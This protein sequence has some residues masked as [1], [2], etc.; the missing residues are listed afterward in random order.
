[1]QALTYLR[2]TPESNI[3]VYY[4]GVAEADR[5]QLQKVREQWP[6]ISD[7]AAHT[8]CS[9]GDNPSEWPRGRTINLWQEATTSSSQAH[10]ASQLATEHRKH[11]RH[12][13]ELWLLRN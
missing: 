10:P 12:E 2:D 4:R 9:N 1:V 7:S 3:L 6:E 11:G 13:P 8:C 5:T